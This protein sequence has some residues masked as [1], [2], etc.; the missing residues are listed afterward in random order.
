MK[1]IAI[2]CILFFVQ[3]S[4][5]DVTKENIISS[6]IELLQKREMSNKQILSLM[7]VICS[8]GESIGI[9]E[10]LPLILGTFAECFKY[11]AICG[12]QL[13][14]K[15]TYPEKLKDK[16]RSESFFLIEIEKTSVI[17]KI[18]DIGK[19]NTLAKGD[20]YMKKNDFDC[21]P[22]HN[23]SVKKIW[24]A[25][26]I[27]KPVQVKI[28]STINFFSVS[29][30]EI[31]KKQ[32]SIKK[33]FSTTIQT[34]KVS[35]DELEVLKSKLNS[36][37]KETTFYLKELENEKYCEKIHKVLKKAWDNNEFLF[38][39][40]YKKRKEKIL[41]TNKHINRSPV[42]I[43]RRLEFIKESLKIVKNLEMEKKNKKSNK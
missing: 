13:Y 22:V 24:E 3:S 35:K 34:G 21:F 6:S 14:N 11:N 16:T 20:V 7:S 38:E 19:L 4:A 18:F 17:K 41:K 27:T 43:R 30:I 8:Q 25:I 23:L 40:D 1:R 26:Y 37:K 9:F 28:G 36:W 42:C 31:N 10:P 29:G 2:Y 5:M 39:P 12:P 33:L 15:N 32:E